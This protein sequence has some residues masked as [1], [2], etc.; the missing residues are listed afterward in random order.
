MKKI[1]P[2]LLAL[3]T[4]Y[5]GGYRQKSHKTS[6]TYPK[7]AASANGNKPLLFVAKKAQFAF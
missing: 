5:R 7:K 6:P 1:R 4:I 3:I 2:M